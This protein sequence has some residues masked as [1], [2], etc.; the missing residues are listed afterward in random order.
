MKR[1][2]LMILF[3]FCVSISWC[4][5]AGCG[6][7]VQTDP[8]RFD[9]VQRGSYAYQ[10]LNDGEFAVVAVDVRELDKA[11][12]EIGCSKQYVCLI[13]TVGSQYQVLI[14]LK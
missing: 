4:A 2:F 6:K 3:S 5:L 7:K 8:T 13:D 1:R 10:R 12:D 11:L 14:R 9:A